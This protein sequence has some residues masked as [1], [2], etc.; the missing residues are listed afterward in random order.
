MFCFWS[1]WFHFY[2]N[3]NQ[4]ATHSFPWTLPTVFCLSSWVCLCSISLC[5]KLRD[6][7]GFLFWFF[8]W[9]PTSPASFLRW[10]DG[11][12]KGRFTRPVA[13]IGLWRS[14]NGA[15]SAQL[16]KPEL[17]VWLSCLSTPSAW[18]ARL[19]PDR[20]FEVPFAPPLNSYQFRV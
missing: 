13:A 14:A 15:Q 5:W 4:C 17:C 12:S 1:N 16:Q 9:L 6:Q 7:R 2:H 20:S 11:P 10:D 18:G 3:K 8:F 19:W